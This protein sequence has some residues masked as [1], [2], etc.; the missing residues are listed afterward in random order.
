MFCFFFSNGF[1]FLQ[2][3]R[4]AGERMKRLH[5]AVGSDPNCSPQPTALP[6]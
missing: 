5:G 1:L 4:V 2:E 6:L 3:D